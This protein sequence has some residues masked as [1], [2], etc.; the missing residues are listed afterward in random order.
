MYA[1]LNK[2]FKQPQLPM[3]NVQ[4]VCEYFGYKSNLAD[5]ITACKIPYTQIRNENVQV[6]VSMEAILKLVVSV[7]SKVFDEMIEK[8]TFVKHNN[9]I[10]EQNK[11]QNSC[12]YI[13][14]TGIRHGKYKVVK[15]GCTTDLGRRVKDLTKKWPLLKLVS[16]YP[17][18]NHVNSEKDIK[19]HAMVKAMRFE[20]PVTKCKE[21]VRIGPE[22]TLENLQE[23]VNQIP[24]SDWK[25]DFQTALE[26]GKEENVIAVLQ[27]ML[28]K[29]LSKEFVQFVHVNDAQQIQ[30]RIE[31]KSN[32]FPL[33]ITQLVK[34]NSFQ[35]M[36][37][38]DKH[39]FEMDL[40]L[41]KKCLVKMADNC[42]KYFGEK[43]KSR[44][45]FE[46]K[47]CQGIDV[48]FLFYNCFCK[49]RFSTRYFPAPAFD[50]RRYTVLV[51]PVDGPTEDTI[52]DDCKKHWDEHDSDVDDV[53]H[54]T[55]NGWY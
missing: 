9:D 53:E 18:V 34:I 26:S 3:V 37:L 54:Q 39:G 8:Y 36:E 45:F 30:K 15:Y 47:T 16:V 12:V 27:D 14:D 25:S 10:V 28:D 43:Y 50:P 44:E 19:K 11:E 38:L 6:L 41:F 55:R 46:G 52:S 4:D 29:E 42:V 13:A 23:I 1:V 17:V 49:N 40:K 22:F 21:L 35:V 20:C 7:K 24:K 5:K 2:A 31:M 51:G 32:K 48:K 33:M